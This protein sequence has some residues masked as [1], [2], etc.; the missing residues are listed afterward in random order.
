M[1]NIIVVR[2][3]GRYIR[4]ASPEEIDAFWNAQPNQRCVRGSFTWA[5]SVVVDGVQLGYDNGPGM[6]YGGAGF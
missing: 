4:D 6:W 2:E 5:Q 3:N 1:E